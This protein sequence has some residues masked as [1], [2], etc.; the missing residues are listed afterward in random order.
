MEAVVV[1]VTV[2]VTSLLRTNQFMECVVVTLCVSGLVG[3]GASSHTAE[4][5]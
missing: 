5:E 1:L 4:T 3:M 2:A